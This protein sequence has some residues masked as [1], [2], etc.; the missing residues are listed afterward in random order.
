MTGKFILREHRNT[1]GGTICQSDFCTSYRGTRNIADRIM[2][3]WA[4]DK[5]CKI[6]ITNRNNGRKVDFT[7][8]K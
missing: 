6:N 2:S 7:K 4:F 8:W 1:Y 3:D 5:K